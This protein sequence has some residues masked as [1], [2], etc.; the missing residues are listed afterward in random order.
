MIRA[1]EILFLDQLIRFQA[2]YDD[3]L[4]VLLLTGLLCLFSFL[5]SIAF[6]WEEKELF[7]EKKQ[8][9][10]QPA[11]LMDYVRSYIQRNFV[12]RYSQFIDRFIVTNISQC[13]VTNIDSYRYY[14]LL[15]SAISN[16]GAVNV[17]P[18][19]I[20]LLFGSNVARTMG[21]MSL[22]KHFSFQKLINLFRSQIFCFFWNGSDFV[23]HHVFVYFKLIYLC[24]M[25]LSFF[26]NYLNK[27]SFFYFENQFLN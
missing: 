5:Y 27:L 12:V 7:Y 3:Q 21:S 15:T 9:T 11:T 6:F 18:A 20:L 1:L 19:A 16:N 2:R 25:T 17:V 24:C 26:L 8:D 10:E 23:E 4:E 13:N 22:E 14:T